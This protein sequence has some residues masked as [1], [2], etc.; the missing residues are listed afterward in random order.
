[1]RKAIINK[2]NPVWI[3]YDLERDSTASMAIVDIKT[4]KY[5]PLVEGESTKTCEQLEAEGLRRI[6][7]RHYKRY[8]IG[9]TPKGAV[10]RIYCSREGCYSDWFYLTA[11]PENM[12]HPEVKTRFWHKATEEDWDLVRNNSNPNVSNAFIHYEKEF[13]KAGLHDAWTKEWNDHGKTTYLL[14]LK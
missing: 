4:M 12:D 13:E 2:D 8:E 9:D 1:M 11:P 14:G 7:V 6:T 10:Y 3:F 5:R